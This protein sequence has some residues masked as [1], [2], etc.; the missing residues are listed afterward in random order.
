MGQSDIIE[1]LEGSDK[2]L[3]R[4]E[5]AIQLNESP[6]KISFLLNKLIKWNEIVFEEID[7]LTA[8]EKYN[9]KRRMNLYSALNK[10][11]N[12]KSNTKPK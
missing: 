7:R 11:P 2:P 5:I 4:S 3:S 6:Q 9:C 10:F 8:R 1:L 12:K